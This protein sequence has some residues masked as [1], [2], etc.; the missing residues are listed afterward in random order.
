M[1]PLV[2]IILINYKNVKDTVECIES[3]YKI[4]Y[5]NYKIIVVDND[6][7]DDIYII[8][9]EN[10]K[11][12]TLIQ[13]KINLGFAGG[14]NL[15][16]KLAIKNNA[17]YIMLLNNDVVVDKDFLNQLINSFDIRNNTGIV[18]CKIKNYYNK[19]IVEYSGGD[20]IWP[21]FKI[22]LHR[23][24]EILCSNENINNVTFISGCAMLIK[25]EVIEKI[26]YLDESY[27]MY[28]EDTDYCV[29][30]L[31]NG[32]RLI[33]QPNSIV[34]HKVSSSS[35][36]NLSPFVL[37][38]STKNRQKFRN[39]FSYKVNKKNLIYFDAFNIITRAIKIIL[40]YMRFDVCSG[41]AIL[42]G[43]IDGI[44]NKN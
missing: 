6:S 36:G 17:D 38:W 1:E 29:R 25:K 9:N 23:K 30:A 43:Y 37:Y 2:Y 33:Y 28:Y 15:G 27:F 42:K 22:Q 16:I 10:Y 8:L 31:D 11:D 14:N 13:S 4:N 34:Y 3:L 40:Y 19:N 26:G 32:Y 41:N 44:M 39:K 7:K 24:Q 20:I 18:G 12:I 35:G 5:Y 21:K